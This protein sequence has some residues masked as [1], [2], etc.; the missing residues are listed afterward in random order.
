MKVAIQRIIDSLNYPLALLNG[1]IENNVIDG[2]IDVLISIRD[3][4]DDILGSIRKLGK[5]IAPD[6]KDEE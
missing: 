6:N 4:R 1:Y 5:T 3:A 2:N